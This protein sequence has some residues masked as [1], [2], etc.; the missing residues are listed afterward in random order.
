MF[1]EVAGSNQLFEKIG[2]TEAAYGVERCV[3][4]MERSIAGHEGRIHKLAD[5]HLLA[6]F[7][8]GDAACQAAVDMQQR[9]SSLSP[10]GGLRLT[11]RIGLHAGRIETNED[12][13]GGEAVDNAMAIARMAGG[14][15][16]LASG[17]LADALSGDSSLLI[18][19]LTDFGQIDEIGEGIG[20]AE[21]EWQRKEAQPAPEARPKAQPAPKAATQPPAEP[22]SLAAE[23]KAAPIEPVAP[24]PEVPACRLVLRF[25]GQTLQ[26]DVTA[27]LITIGRDP[28]SGIV[29]DDRKVSRAHARIERR[30]DRY[31]FVDASTN[32]SYI[33]DE[34]GEEIA[35]HRGEEHELDGKG[36]LYFGASSKDPKAAFAEFERIR[37]EGDVKTAAAQR[38]SRSTGKKGAAKA[39][40][41]RRQRTSS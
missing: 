17:T 26:V 15:Q 28:A 37:P 4:R 14:D 8:S 31:V 36:H 11:I 29:I 5:G 25:R 6:T 39:A 30:E 33:R 22:V 19:A 20:L 12:G 3:N 27:P 41:S 32:G 1:A 10:L 16:I 34:A 9:V 2:E 13:I 40:T 7:E 21:I 24:P 18:W 38:P 35:L 23:I